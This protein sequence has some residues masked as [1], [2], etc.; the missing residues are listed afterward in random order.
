MCATPARIGRDMTGKM[1]PYST[2]AGGGCMKTVTESASTTTGGVA[3]RKL[4][5]IVNPMSGHGWARRHWPRIAS[6][7]R[8]RGYEVDARFT[9]RAGDGKRVGQQA[10]AD[11]ATEIVVVG[12]DGTLNEAVNGI[13]GGPVEPTPDLVLSLLPCGSGRDFSRSLGIRSFDHALDTLGN[14]EIIAVDVGK[15]DFTR[16]GQPDAWFFLNVADVGIGAET[17][18]R[19]QA[20]SKRLGGFLSYLIGVATTIAVFKGK[21]VTVHVDGELIHDGPAGMVCLANG[22]F[23]AG[24]MRLAPMASLR[25]G[26]FDVLVLD[27][28]PKWTLLG[29]LLPRV[30]FGKHIGHYA[31]RHMLGRA[32]EVAA[33]EPL[34]FEADGEQPGTTDFRAEI[35][36]GAL[37]VRVPPGY[38]NLEPR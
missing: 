33:R 19:L 18:A 27:D 29:S 36:A 22:R 26:Q 17:V 13:F 12:G 20:S 37:R 32:V 9:E 5:A 14:G 10:I 21:P 24:G 30:Y 31:V 6:Q 1:A 15:V 4:H 3:P 7:L 2:K 28:V 11:G 38:D 23:H 25:D 34:L 35:L 8:Q 16:D